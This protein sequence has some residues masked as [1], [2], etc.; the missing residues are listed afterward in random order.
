MNKEKVPLV[1]QILENSRES[2]VYL[3]KALE[4]KP[5]FWAKADDAE[6]PVYTTGTGFFVEPDKFLTTIDVVTGGIEITASLSNQFKTEG[7][8]T[9]HDIVKRIKNRYHNPPNTKEP[10]HISEDA[11]LT[12]EG[13]SAFDPKNNLVLLKVAETGTPLPLANS[14]SVKV[15]DTVY[16]VGHFEDIGALGA[17]GKVESRY[18]KDDALL[19][20]D[21]SFFSSACGAPVLN[22]DSEVIGIAFA[23]PSF[24]SEDNSMSF[25]RAISSNLIQQLIASSDKVISLAQWQKYLQV[26]AYIIASEADEMSELHEDMEAI[27]SYDK[28]LRFN[29]DLIEVY[30]RRGLAKTRVGNMVGALM[31]L[32]KAIAINPHDTIAYN[33]RAATKG[34][35]GDIHGM[36]ADLNKAI[37]LNPNYLLGFLNR[38]QAKCDLAKCEIEDANITEARRLGQEAIDDFV[39]VLELN[40]KHTF[41]RQLLRNAKQSLKK[42]DLFNKRIN[43]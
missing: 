25:C 34:A 35:L 15:D 33:N 22:T 21:T 16:V 43:L 19:Q 42:L 11:M 3:Q 23:G 38:G 7:V 32:N 37:Q 6:V 1:E 39:R 9:P 29:P 10:P 40:P 8:V 28:A 41:A 26:R 20:I 4:D 2:I 18:R 24:I 13:V 17:A 30:A 27:K 31:D 5:P 12:I 14:D 36:L